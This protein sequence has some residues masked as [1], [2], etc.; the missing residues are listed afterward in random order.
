MAPLVLTR[1]AYRDKV[2][3]GW[4]G[5]N[6]GVTLGAGVAGQTEAHSFTFYD[7]LPGQPAASEE[8]DMQLAA[9]SALR[10]HGPDLRGA[11]VA[12]AWVAHIRYTFDEAG[13]AGRNLRRGL[14]PPISGAFDNWFR[15]GNSGA[16]RTLLWAMVAPGAPQVAAAYAFEDA[17]IDHS[18]EGVWAAMFWAAAQS[19]AFFVSDAGRL[20]DIGLSMVP[21]ASRVSLAVRTARQVHG[22]RLSWLEARTRVLAAVG[23]PN[24][25]DAP[26][27]AGFGAMGL[28]YG[29]GDFGGA[30]CSAAN[31]GYDCDAVGGTVGGLMGI[32]AGRSGMPARW[33]EPIGEA[34]VMGWGLV[35]LAAPLTVAD[36]AAQV[37]EAGEQ[38]VVARCADVELVDEMPAEE[39]A[40]AP[41]PV[42]EPVPEPPVVE[43]APPAE[44]APA[45]EEAPSEEAA[46]APEL[47]P[48]DAAVAKLGDG[49]TVAAEEAPEPEQ[50]AGEAAEPPAADAEA[51]L[52]VDAPAAAP[53]PPLAEAPI[54]APAPPAPKPAYDW[55]ANSLVKPLLAAPACS[56][57]HHV[58]QFEVVVDY[59]EQ[60]PAIIPNV[61]TT[62]MMM[63]RNRGESPFV[64]N[65]QLSVPRGWEA[66]VPGAQGQRQML[67]AGGMARY[68]FVVRAPEAAP[69]EGRNDLALVLAPESGPPTTVSFSLLGG[70]GWYVVGPFKNQMDDG[71]ERAF[72][73]EDKPG[74]DCTYLGRAG[75]LVRWARHA[76]KETVMDVEPLFEGHPGVLYARTRFH[77]PTITDC[78]IVLHTN[79][80]GKVW[81]N[82]RMVLQRHWHAPFRPT[83][84]EGACMV[85]VTLR[86]GDNDLM[87]KVVRCAEPAELALMVVDR[88]GKPLESVV[89]KWE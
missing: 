8:T 68:G 84:G 22:A 34:V 50:A 61:A 85:D 30:V 69:L 28:L 24:V 13:Y 44:A 4:L 1:D 88:K 40:P 15:R 56:S 45:A 65:V 55:T 20:L 62:L 70:S 49:E 47:S 83:L 57:T 25:T 89:G 78:R 32:V 59:G 52:A 80:G 73:P 3:G 75:G 33:V 53:E 41:E 86:A 37:V 39:P 81:L 77:V 26:Q 29:A 18:E 82:S 42:P 43:A 64:G 2:E 9:F 51:P 10:E 67:A 23:H 14:R 58:G 72:E 11:D 66:R 17:R 6:A 5:R 54:A 36:L 87:L 60:G 21:Q 7:P 16:G 31:C 19:A 38:V 46:P 48:G 35:D 12:D 79:D 74:L 63:V 71:F 27:N 76:F